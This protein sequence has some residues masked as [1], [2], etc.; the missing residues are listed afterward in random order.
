MKTKSYSLKFNFLYFF[1][2]LIVL[3][4]C[5][6]EDP[7]R[8]DVPELI[9]RITLRFTPTDGG[10]VIE[11]SASDPDGEGVA[12][13]EADGPAVLLAG[14]TYD[15]EI[16]LLNELVNSGQSGYDI[17]A[18]VEEEGDEHMLFF[19]WD[20]ALFAEPIGNGNADNRNDPV[21][22]QDSDQNNL[23]L[24]LTTRWTTASTASSGKLRIVL[25]HQP[26][27]KTANSGLSTGE[28]DLDVTFDVTIQ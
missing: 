15:L 20:D 14:K 7:V 19:A 16:L 2:S 21:L 28:T 17:S 18:E 5:S 23:P 3:F 11:A 9:T 24:G 1:V 25:K 10:N 4:A 22:Y 6:P 13:I 26:D 27:T 12:D 8:E